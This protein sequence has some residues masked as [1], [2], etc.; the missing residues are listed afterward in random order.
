MGRAFLRMRNLEL[1]YEI[2][3]LLNE[4][5]QLKKQLN[6]NK[7]KDITKLS[8]TNKH[9]DTIDYDNIVKD[10]ECYLVI[11]NNE[12]IFKIYT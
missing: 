5:E 6:E 12:V 3:K 2:D 9:G 7:T 8:V 11:S 4:N 10:G 1:R